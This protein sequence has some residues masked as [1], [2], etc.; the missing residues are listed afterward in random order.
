MEILGAVVVALLVAVMAINHI[1][2]KYEK[3]KK[4]S[5]SEGPSAEDLIDAAWDEFGGDEPVALLRRRVERLA[6]DVK[7]EK[8]GNKT[9]VIQFAV[10]AARAERYDL[11]PPLAE[12][13]EGLDEGCGET[14]TLRALSEALTGN[15]F[16]RAVEAIQNAQSAAAGCAKC[17]SSIESKLLAEELAIA[18]DGLEERFAAEEAARRPAGAQPSSPAQ[19]G[20]ASTHGNLAVRVVRR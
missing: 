14:R 3:G 17:S 4:R 12:R 7:L 2:A 15:D 8:I 6:K 13:A 16:D 20:P 5:D 11:L 18:A 9:A 1:N 10:M 19:S